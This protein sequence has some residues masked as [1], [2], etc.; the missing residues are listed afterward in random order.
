VAVIVANYVKRPTGLPLLT[1][2]GKPN[3][4]LGPIKFATAIF[5]FWGVAGIAIGLSR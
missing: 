3:Y 2:D 1:I 4:N 5:L